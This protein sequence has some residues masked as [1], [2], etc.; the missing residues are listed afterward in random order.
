[1][2]IHGMEGTLFVAG[3]VLFQR[4]EMLRLRIARKSNELQDLNIPDRLAHVPSE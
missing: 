2:E 3:S 1:M 4:G